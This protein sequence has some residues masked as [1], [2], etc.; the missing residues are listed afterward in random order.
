MCFGGDSDRSVLRLRPEG[1]GKYLVFLT[2]GMPET[3]P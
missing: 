2:A 3:Y 1:N